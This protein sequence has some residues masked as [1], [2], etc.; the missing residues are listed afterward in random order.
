MSP[1][2]KLA[3]VLGLA[4][5]ADAIGP[6]KGSN[7]AR[8]EIGAKGQVQMSQA[9]ASCPSLMEFVSLKD[10]DKLATCNDGSPAGFWYKP[11][12]DKNLYTIFLM[13]GDD[14]ID[15]QDCEERF[16]SKPDLVG[17]S[18][19][20]QTKEFGGLFDSCY[21]VLGKGTIAYTQYCTSDLYMG[22]NQEPGFT[23]QLKGW[24]F[25]GQRH[26]TALIQHMVEYKGLGQAEGQKLVFGGWSAGSYG[27]VNWL[28]FVSQMLDGIA[29]YKVQVLGAFDGILGFGPK[30]EERIKK[31]VPLFN[32]WGMINQDCAA[33]IGDSPE[34][35]LIAHNKL[36]YLK[37]SYIMAMPQ[38]DAFPCTQMFGSCSFPLTLEQST[39]LEK[40]AT[41]VTAY[42]SKPAPQSLSSCG[43]HYSYQCFEHGMSMTEGWYKVHPQTSLVHPG[44]TLNT[45]VSQALQLREGECIEP[46]FDT[47]TTVDC[48][49]FGQTEKHTHAEVFDE[50]GDASIAWWD[51][52]ASGHREYL[53]NVKV[54]P[55]AYQI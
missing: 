37:S 9:P 8:S 32:A 15:E 38:T 4:G 29:P 45:L 44:W 23:G 14:C 21:S 49:C 53:R 33:N 31:Q 25:N 11:G 43:M 1:L 55:Q 50:P 54:D 24:Q 18:H 19:L 51:D 42:M 2:L 40:F 34:H 39:W 35:C 17:T 22:D 16:M 10:T 46:I 3:L 5:T 36:P 28:D 41:T 26:V 13:G 47:C 7:F 30:M 20:S 48:G 6:S 27:A 52:F 12:E